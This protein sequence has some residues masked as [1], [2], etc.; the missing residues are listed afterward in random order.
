MNSFTKILITFSLLLFTLAHSQAQ[1]E[2]KTRPIGIFTK[3]PGLS[4]E[5]YLNPSFSL[6]MDLQHTAIK[7]IYIPLFTSGDNYYLTGSAASLLPKFYFSSKKSSEGFYGFAILKYSTIHGDLVG[8]ERSP[9]LPFGKAGGGIGLKKVLGGKFV[10]EYNVGFNR[11]LTTK[12]ITT[13]DPDN[14]N[15]T[16]IN[17]DFHEIYGI[18]SRLSFGY[19][20]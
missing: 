16:F 20:F 11:T 15:I 7:S 18:V 10:M 17:Y 5:Y 19:R 13:P 14:P 4:I 6:E 3:H 1:V 9:D 8:L 12:P 2:L